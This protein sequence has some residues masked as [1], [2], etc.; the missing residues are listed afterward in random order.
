MQK[1]GGGN[2]LPER[3]QLQIYYVTKIMAISNPFEERFVCH[4]PPTG[5]N[6]SLDFDDA[7][8]EEVTEVIVKLKNP[9][10]YPI[11]VHKKEEVRQ[12]MQYSTGGIRMYH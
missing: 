8:D 3:S 9:D 6:S 5:H 1:L 2:T 7:D 10:G 4:S 12:C 11:I